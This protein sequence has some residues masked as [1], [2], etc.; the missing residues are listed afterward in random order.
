MKR[1]CRL[2]LS[3][4]DSKAELVELG[5]EALASGALELVGA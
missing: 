5:G 4:G 1:S 2:P 3:E